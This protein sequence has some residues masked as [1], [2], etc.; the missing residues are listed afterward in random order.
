MGRV[1]ARRVFRGG[2]WAGLVGMLLVAAGCGDDTAPK[3]PHNRVM[4]G[5]PDL[6]PTVTGPLPDI[7]IEHS[8]LTLEAPP[9]GYLIDARVLVISAD[10]NENELDAIT[11]TLRY[12]GTPYDT[13]IASQRSTLSTSDLTVS[14][15]HGRYNG[16]ILTTGT[17]PLSGTST[18]AFSTGEFQTLASY[19]GLFQVRRASLYTYPD[20]G[21]GYTGQ[22]AVASLPLTATCT[23]AGRT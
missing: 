19:E 13:F 12:L 6:P 1:G 7:P 4:R 2:V 15:T 10:G 23:A 8:P 18:S 21:Y 5:P 3:P 17:L 16:I 20:A 9:P 11:E 14:S 22:P